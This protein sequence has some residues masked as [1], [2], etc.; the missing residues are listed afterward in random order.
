[1]GQN[2]R[3]R[4]FEKSAL[5]FTFDKHLLYDITLLLTAS[6]NVPIGKSLIYNLLHL[7][8]HLQETWED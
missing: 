1:M 8:G 4:S 2:L 3:I 7:A 5:N 6:L